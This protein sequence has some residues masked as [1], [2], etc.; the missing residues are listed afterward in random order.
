MELVICS[1]G[2][3]EVVFAGRINGRPKKCPACDL[4]EGYGKNIEE[5]RNEIVN[6]TEDNQR[7]KNE[8]NEVL[9]PVIEAAR[10]ERGLEK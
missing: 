4:V 8:L 3:E 1:S 5:L 10:G 2:H 7:L 9:G 6:L